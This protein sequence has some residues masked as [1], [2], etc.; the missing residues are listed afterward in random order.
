[1]K[2]EVHP[3]AYPPAISVDPRLQQHLYG[4]LLFSLF[5]D[6]PRYLSL[7]LSSFH[8]AQNLWRDSGGGSSVAGLGKGMG[9]QEAGIQ[10]KGQQPTASA[11]Q[12]SSPQSDHTKH[13]DLE[14]PPFLPSASCFHTRPRL[15]PLSLLGIHGKRPPFLSEPQRT[16]STAFL[17]TTPRKL[18][19]PKPHPR[20]ILNLCLLAYG[21]HYCPGGQW[22]QPT[23][24]HPVLLSFLVSFS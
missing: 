18:L 4:S 7:S 21:F 13:P 5:F 6:L 14:S 1:M 10:N 20:D 16:V 17:T 11:P 15:Y 22:L 12:P 9:P 24:C 23:L 8:V 2:I 3:P 19:S